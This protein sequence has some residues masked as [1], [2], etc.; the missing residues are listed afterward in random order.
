MTLGKLAGRSYE[1]KKAK[2]IVTAGPYFSCLM[3]CRTE[4]FQALKRFGGFK[5]PLIMVCM[6]E[7]HVPYCGNCGIPNDA[8]HLLLWPVAGHAP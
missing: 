6:Y 1:K 4:G 7:R 3:C 8:I 2:A 5:L